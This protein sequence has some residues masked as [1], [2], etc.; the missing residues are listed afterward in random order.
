MVILLSF[1][2]PTHITVFTLSII[3]LACFWVLADLALN[4]RLI[5]MA[6]V[7]PDGSLSTTVTS[8]DTLNF[9]I[10]GGDRAGNNLFHSFEQF[11]IPTNGSARFNNEASLDTIISRITG[12]QQSAID[13]LVQ[14]N[15][16]ADLFLVNPS[17][18]V[19]GPNARL[20]IGGAFIATTADSVV[21]DDGIEFSATT[22]T[23]TSLLSINTPIGL[24]MG[25]NPGAITLGGPGHTLT[26]TSDFAPVI[27]SSNQP[28]LGG[29]QGQLIG[30]IGGDLDL[31]GASITAPG[32]QIELGSVRQ[33]FVALH[34]P[35]NRSDWQF[36]YDAVDIF[37]DIQLSQR[38]LLN[39]S[40]VPAG[41]VGLWGDRIQLEEGSI[42]LSQNSGSLPARPITINANRRLAVD[43]MA[44]SDRFRSAIQTATNLDSVAQGSA[45]DINTRRLVIQDRG[46][47]ITTTYGS[48]TSGN[49]NI[50]AT[51]RVDILGAAA[52]LAVGDLL[53]STIGTISLRNDGNAG[54]IHI[55]VPRLN[56]EGGLISSSTIVGNGMGGAVN[57]NADVITL[58]GSSA[59]N[60]GISTATLGN[61]NSGNIHINTRILDLQDGNVIDSSALAA[62]RAG[63]ITIFASEQIIVG[64]Q[65]GNEQTGNEQTGNEQTGNEQTGHEQA[66]NNESVIS[67]TVL[68]P[69]ENTQELL[70]VSLLPT[71]QAGQI[72]LN[73]PYL[74]LEN[75]GGIITSAEGEGVAGRLAINANQIDLVD[76]GRILATNDNNSGGNIQITTDILRIDNG[77]INAS[78]FQSGRGGKIAIRANER[79]ELVG[80]G[81]ETLGDNLIIP[82]LEGTFDPTNLTQG[83]AAIALNRGRAGIIDIQTNDLQL[84]QGSIITTVAFAES[85]GGTIRLQS[86]R[87][88]LLNESVI[89][90]STLGSGRAGDMDIQTAE[91]LLQNGSQIV[92]ST[93]GTGPAGN[94][95]IHATEQAIFSGSVQLSDRIFLTGLAAGNLN[96]A[97]G[98]SGDI[99]LTTP[100]LVLRDGANVS[101]SALVDAPNANLPPIPD[102]SQA[103]NIHATIGTLILDQGSITARSTQD[104]GGNIF[105]ELG[106]RL[107]L[108]NQSTISTQAG[109]DTSG[110]GNGGNINL[111]VP[112][113]FARNNSDIIANAFEGMGGNIQITTQGL[114]GIDFREVLTPASD[115]TASSTFGVGGSV[116]IQTPEVDPAST[117][118]LLPS[119]PTDES[120]QVATGCE[121]VS[122]SQFIITGRGG[123]PLAPSV[124]RPWTSL[125]EDLG[126]VPAQDNDANIRTGSAEFPEH[127]EI[128][129]LEVQQLDPEQPYAPGKLEE[130]VPQPTPD[131]QPIQE[132]T[133]M[134]IAPDGTT[135]L[136]AN[137]PLASSIGSFIPCSPSP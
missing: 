66:A 129:N 58:S 89:T 65:P 40:G 14:T 110:G 12:G 118:T 137:H 63:N 72:T 41:E 52:S 60:P 4:S 120:Q 133:Q 126:T 80:Q 19:F 53:D 50:N 62:G 6:Q 130:L 29:T 100:L 125:L 101:V 90:T 10:D 35:E 119:T 116:T 79:I 98:N 84:T 64:G 48:G 17:G 32:G 51:G 109:T 95:A 86:D 74:R 103:G 76:G 31:D 114:F 42:I 56:L 23:P 1:M 70:G 99:T 26:Q 112:F 34:Q 9:D 18:F 46:A 71:G 132:A 134:A 136:I 124:Y 96:N 108:Q 57:I 106:D 111:T 91:F 39:V 54:D 30:L 88:L 77:L 16:T 81:V 127:Q 2:R 24:Q 83:I 28:G 104:K 22:P 87:R 115:I 92:A 122:G 135:K 20:D 73:T 27:A 37:G 69:P 75:Q 36:N 117:T 121:Q 38:S 59:R 8:S 33:G 49:I 97:L 3:R 11:S 45:I 85:Q 13:G 43:G 128:Q 5:A 82:A 123:V 44:T 67:A 107:L 7:V 47:V 68:K 113:V 105:L 94:L 131:H 25:T 21:F 78:T 15:G 55:Q 102:R 61:G 93:G